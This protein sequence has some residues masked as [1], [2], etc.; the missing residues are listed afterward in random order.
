MLYDG[1]FNVIS[2]SIRNSR[3]YMRVQ[4]KE[5][6]REFTLF[7]IGAH[8]LPFGDLKVSFVKLTRKRGNW[9]EN[10]K[11]DNKKS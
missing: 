7:F 3:R 9:H 11:Q 10:K 5:Q 6:E 1:R 8:K 2:L 4:L